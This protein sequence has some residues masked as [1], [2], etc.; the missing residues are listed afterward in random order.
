L[1]K[2]GLAPAPLLEQLAAKG[3]RISDFA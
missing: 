3:Q 1:K 2:Y